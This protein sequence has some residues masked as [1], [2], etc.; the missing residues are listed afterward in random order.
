MLQVENL[1]CFTLELGQKLNQVE[2]M[3]QMTIRPVVSQSGEIKPGIPRLLTQTAFDYFKDHPDQPD[4]ETALKI[5][6][7]CLE[8][9]NTADLN[10]YYSP[11]IITIDQKPQIFIV[12]YPK[13]KMVSISSHRMNNVAIQHEIPTEEHQ[14][15][16][17]AAAEY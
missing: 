11:I 3:P 17:A 12:S 10:I 9:K 4:L 16:A 7:P 1:S 13:S 15:F 8:R 14:A 6:E 2:L 5:L